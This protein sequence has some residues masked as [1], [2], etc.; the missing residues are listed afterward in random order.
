MRRLSSSINLAYVSRESSRPSCSTSSRKTEA[1]LARSTLSLERSPSS[2]RASGPADC[3]PGAPRFIVL[4][5][6][7]NC[8]VVELCQQGGRGARIVVGR[9][10]T[11]GD[12][13]NSAMVA[14]THTGAKRR[15]ER[16]DDE[17]TRPL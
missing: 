13:G 2:V 17:T 14:H 4:P 12:R 8:G 16:R 7:V 9:G 11:R 3:G 1:A 5:L 6:G 15:T 10:R